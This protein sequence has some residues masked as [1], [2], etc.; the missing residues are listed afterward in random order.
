MLVEWLSSG[1]PNPRTQPGRM[2]SII[3]LILL[4]EYLNQRTIKR[5]PVYR[6]SY[7]DQWFSTGSGPLFGCG[8]GI[9]G[10]FLVITVIEGVLS[11]IW[12][13]GPRLT[14]VWNSSIEQRNCSAWLSNAL[15][16]IDMDEKS[17]YN[18][19]NIDPNSNFLSSLFYTYGIM[20][21]KTFFSFAKLDY[22]IY[23]FH[24]KSWKQCFIIQR[25]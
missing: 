2:A 9:M 7:S 13:L 10:A 21:I 25:G 16:G 6:H 14:D 8:L 20:Q 15:Q 1:L 17:I 22:M 18:Y 5:T 24:L 23:E 4:P 3:H 11:G 12:W 19:F